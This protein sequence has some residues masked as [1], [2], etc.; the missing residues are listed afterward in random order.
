MFKILTYASKN[1]S[2]IINGEPFS[3]LMFRI[4]DEFKAIVKSG[5]FPVNQLELMNCYY[6]LLLF[7]KL[8]V[9]IELSTSEYVFNILQVENSSWVTTPKNNI[10]LI[11]K[12]RDLILESRFK[13]NLKKVPTREYDFCK[14]SLQKFLNKLI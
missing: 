1:S 2:T 4:N 8:E 11:S 3:I 14:E 10:Y 13:L 6:S 9:D 5:H 12:L 7:S